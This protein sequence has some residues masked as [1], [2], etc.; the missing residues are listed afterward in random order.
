[1]SKI[2]ER[3]KKLVELARSEEK[4]GNIEAAA[5]IAAKVQ[6]MLLRHDLTM[7]DVEVAESDKEGYVMVTCTPPPHILRRHR[8]GWQEDLAASIAEA[9]MCKSLVLQDSNVQVFAGKKQDAEVCD[10]MY[11]VLVTAAVQIADESYEATINRLYANFGYPRDCGLLDNRLVGFKD[12]FYVGFVLAIG[13]RYMQTAKDIREEATKGGESVAMIRL[14]DQLVEIDRF[15][16]DNLGVGEAP[17][18]NDSKPLDY[19]GF[20]QGF[21][22]G[23]DVNIQANALTNGK[24]DE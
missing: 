5:T 12:A 20:M 9:H 6:R 24:K 16:R 13:N 19:Q 11:M 17:E 15:L 14:T 1:M 18:I 2:L 4:L 23:M 8:V 7:D 21:R 10:Y 22:E 3:I